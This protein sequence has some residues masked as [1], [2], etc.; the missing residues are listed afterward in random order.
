MFGCPPPPDAR[1]VLQA[2]EYSTAGMADDAA[3]AKLA[4]EVD[5]ARRQLARASRKVETEPG[6]SDVLLLDVGAQPRLRSADVRSRDTREFP[7]E[8]VLQNL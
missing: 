1:E 2:L 8:R 3:A 6:G 4:K 5:H 7:Y